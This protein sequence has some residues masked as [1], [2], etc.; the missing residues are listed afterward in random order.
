MLV[1]DADL[2]FLRDFSPVVRDERGGIA[3][4]VYIYPP[5][6]PL[7]FAKLGGRMKNVTTHWLR[8]EWPQRPPPGAPLAMCTVHHMTVVQRS[9]LLELAAHVRRLHGDGV[10]MLDVFAS[11]PRTTNDW[12]ISEYDLYFTFMWHRHRDMMVG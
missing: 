1:L 12:Y 6:V 8:M 2:V 4:L 7:Q 11:S 3:K 5:Y 9:V 10:T